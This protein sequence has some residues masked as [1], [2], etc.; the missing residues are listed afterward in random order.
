M[1]TVDAGLLNAQIPLKVENYQP[2]IAGSIARGYTL[3]DGIGQ[4]KENQR[5]RDQ[6]QSDQEIM[7]GLDI[8][9]PDSFKKT[10]SDPEL[11]EK[12]GKLSPEM[13][14]KIMDHGA[15]MEK[16][17]LSIK[18][19]A[20]KYDDAENEQRLARMNEGIKLFDDPLN[21]VKEAKAKGLP[22]D[23]IEAGYKSR[24]EIAFQNANRLQN[25]ENDPKK[26][27]QLRNLASLDPAALENVRTH[28]AWHIKELED[29]RKAK[30]EEALIKERESTTRLNDRSVGKNL[31]PVA[32]IN[33]EVA[34]GAITPEQGQA[35]I[36]AIEDKDR[37]L[38]DQRNANVRK[39]NE[40]V[41]SLKSSIPDDLVSGY[42]E[43]VRQGEDIRKVL[44]KA[45]TPDNVFKIGLAAAAKNKEEGL[46]EKN[47]TLL[48]Q[49]NKERQ[50]ALTQLGKD[51]SRVLKNEST[52]RS[53]LKLALSTLSDL[54]KQGKTSDTNMFN[55]VM[56]D[57]GSFLG[58]PTWGRLAADVKS[59]TTE[60]ANVMTGMG[61]RTTVS[62]I[63]D[64]QKILSSA[65]NPEK[66]RAVADELTKEMEGRKQAFKDDRKRISSMDLSEIAGGSPKPKAGDSNASSVIVPNVDGTMPVKPPFVGDLPDNPSNPERLTNRQKAIN[67]QKNPSS[68]KKLVWD[69]ST[70]SFK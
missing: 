58:D 19:E 25:P 51:E 53:S 44:G 63:N 61:G 4:A 33:Q 40:Q 59:F 69:Q 16:T 34:S 56:K 1:A 67:S 37:S 65:D 30:S 32:K 14:A 12:I 28:A 42:A 8:Y 48:P 9:T 2:D 64:A 20:L 26:T 41:K 3:A 17:A 11:K 46:D 49:L 27:E 35:R 18:N 29:L 23:Q 22:Q 66:F 15:S 6:K 60:Y 43:R 5:G 45:A 62:A 31:D 10:M 38:I 24:A 7:S 47:A 57:Y 39:M 55:K 68:G 50:A 13:R 21:F 36:A 52:A 70:G 54:E